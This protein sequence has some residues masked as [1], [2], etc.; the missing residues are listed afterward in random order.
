M[1]RLAAYSHASLAH[2]QAKL[3]W[4]GQMGFLIKLGGT[5][6][7]IDYYATPAED[8]QVAPII[9]AAELKGVDLFIGTHDHLDHIDHE[10]WRIWKDTCPDAMFVFPASHI[11]V[12]HSDGIDFMR[13]VPMADGLTRQVGEVTVT[14]IAAA[15]EFL[16]RN[17]VTG[18]H[19]ALQYIIRGNG[20][21]IYHAGDTCRYEGMLGKLEALKPIDC[22]ILPINGRDAKR[23]RRNC[24]GNMTYQ[25]SVDLAGELG[26]RLVIPGHWDMFRDNSEDPHA[27]KDYLEVK[28]G[29]R[30]PCVIPVH[31]QPIC[32]GL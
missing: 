10:S 26:P 4:L 8:R 1:D 21:T 29:D 7:V 19:P 5:T 15:H 12:V 23:L 28:Y 9:P 32:I 2:G 30:V 3:W 18:Y 25:E 22:A 24:I 27:F 6:I 16:D 31:A 17:P 14:A 20:V 13:M 11:G